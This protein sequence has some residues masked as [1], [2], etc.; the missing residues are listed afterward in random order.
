MSEGIRG[1]YDNALYKLMYTLLLTLC[2]PSLY[3]SWLLDA[4]A[5]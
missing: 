3:V 5:Q 1:S 4:N 2:H